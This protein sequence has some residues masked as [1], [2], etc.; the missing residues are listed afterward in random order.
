MLVL[1]DP[2]DAA[3]IEDEQL[4]RLVDLRFAQ[5]CAGEPYDAERHGYAVVVE[6]G[7]EIEAIEEAVGFPV[8]SNAFGDARYGDL[9]FTPAAE[10]IEDHGFCYELV[11]V[12]SDDGAGVELFVAKQDEVAPELVAMCAE[13]A[14]PAAHPAR[15]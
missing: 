7:D 12:L 14:V 2:R 6:P 9:A 1:R 3:D 5:V 4:R 11:Y 13:F 8:L 10:V 15:E